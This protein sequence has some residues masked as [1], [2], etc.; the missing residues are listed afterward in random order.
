MIVWG[1]THENPGVGPATYLAAGEAYEPA[2]NS[3]FAVRQYPAPSGRAYH[4]AVW[5]GSRMIIWGGTISGDH[6]TD[7]GGSYNADPFEDSWRDIPP[8]STFF[9]PPA[10]EPLGLWVGSAMWVGVPD[11]RNNGTSFG[12]LYNPIADAWVKFSP[13][14]PPAGTF[15]CSL[16]QGD[17]TAVWN[18]S[19]VLV[20]WGLCGGSAYDPSSNS[21]TSMA[22]TEAPS[23]RRSHTA[24]W[25]GRQMIVWGGDNQTSVPPFNE[26]LNTGGVWTPASP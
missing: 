23:A 26:A 24:V 12:A 17:S 21:W 2:T 18:G 13:I 15:R 6:P 25:T 22:K 14:S 19:R 3:W 10:F 8:S 20:W 16:S 1:G 5:T 9:L 7:T 4:A 11:P